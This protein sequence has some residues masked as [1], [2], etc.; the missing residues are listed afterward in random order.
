MTRQLGVITTF[1]TVL[2]ASVALAVPAVAAAPPNDLFADAE[3][4]STELPAAASGTLAESTVEPAEFGLYNPLGASV[5]YSWTAPEGFDKTLRAE[6]C[7]DTGSDF[8]GENTIYSG[9]ALGALAPIWFDF[10]LCKVLSVRPD[11]GETIRIQVGGA[12]QY[13]GEHQSFTISLTDT[14]TPANDDIE[15]AIPVFGP[16]PAP[17]T[18]DNYGATGATLQELS[19]FEVGNSL[20]YRFGIAEAG[21]LEFGTCAVGFAA[22]AQLFDALDPEAV[23]SLEPVFTDS[24]FPNSGCQEPSL[25]IHYKLNVEAGDQ[26]LLG[27]AT[28]EVFG[29]DAYGDVTVSFGG[30]AVLAPRASNMLRVAKVKVN[31]KQGSAR[32]TVQAGGAGR[33]EVMGSAKVRAASKTV[34]A[35]GR[36]TLNVKPKGSLAKK[37][38]KIG[39][40]KVKVKFRFSPSGLGGESRTVTR[41]VTLKRR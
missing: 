4:L 39:K 40:A 33:V 21:K 35:A 12:D 11:S 13:P 41:T 30:D 15:N 7:K 8:Y 24:T 1:A 34:G 10:G 32:V 31:R 2:L 3:V 28:E 38:R 25:G 23:Q 20:W 6:I 14:E 29:G 9:S 36:L 27:V 16:D 17:V 5:W 18:G 19:I 22:R 37:L 26:F